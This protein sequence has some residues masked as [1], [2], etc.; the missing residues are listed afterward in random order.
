MAFHVQAKDMTQDE[1]NNFVNFYREWASL[2]EEFPKYQ[3]VKVMFIDLNQDGV[4]EALATSKG[5]EYEDGSDWT[6]F[7]FNSEKWAK[8]PEYDART[9]KIG[10]TA[11]FFGRSGEFFRVMHG[12]KVEF[13]I[14]SERYDKLA[15]DGKRPLNKTRFHL[16]DDGIMR[17]SPISDIER[18]I[19]YRSS[20]AEWPTNT[21]IMSLIRLP[22]EVFPS[23]T[24]EEK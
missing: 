5:F 20:G 17:Q 11:T 18:F 3:E 10:K 8:I 13:C 22:V 15:K 19:A 7:R 12:D 4:F 14:L 23:P 2:A 24:L 1:K 16:D 9:E 6:A 21:T